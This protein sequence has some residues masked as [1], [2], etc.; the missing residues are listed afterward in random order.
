M[1]RLTSVKI[2]EYSCE[3]QPG[4]L[5]LRDFV[6]LRPVSALRLDTFRFALLFT[7]FL[8]RRSNAAQ[9]LVRH[10]SLTN[11]RFLRSVCSQS[12]RGANPLTISYHS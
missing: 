11:Q 8:R 5:A 9:A 3:Q 12:D 6:H 10:F 4:S 1:F 2:G 7:T